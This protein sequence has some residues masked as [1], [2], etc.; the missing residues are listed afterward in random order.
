[1]EPASGG[2]RAAVAPAAPL[3]AL[4]PPPAVPALALEGDQPVFLELVATE[5]VFLHDGSEVPS[6]MVVNDAHRWPGGR[7]ST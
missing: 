4:D 2:G 5:T 3:H 6:G 7:S 1:M